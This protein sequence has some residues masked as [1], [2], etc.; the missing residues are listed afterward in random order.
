[1]RV[2]GGRGLDSVWAPSAGPRGQD[3]RLTAGATPALQFAPRDVQ[4][5]SV[6]NCAAALQNVDTRLDPALFYSEI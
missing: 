2:W 4:G 1:M 3:A 5:G 6:A